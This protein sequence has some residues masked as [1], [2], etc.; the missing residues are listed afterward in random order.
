MY[1]LRIMSI[2]Y[3][4]FHTLT[5]C[6]VALA[7]TFYASL[8]QRWQQSSPH[9]HSRAVALVAAT[10]HAAPQPAA[11]PLVNRCPDRGGVWVN[12]AVTLHSSMLGCVVCAVMTVAVSVVCE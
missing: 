9:T 10:L 3:S 8:A 11:L 5:T 4:S 6:L 12:G 7:S 1:Q 2:M